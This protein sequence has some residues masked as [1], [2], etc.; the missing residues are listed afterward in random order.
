MSQ[1][2]LPINDQK[3]LDL[4]LTHRSYLN[5]HKNR[6]A[7]NERLEFLGDAVL[8]LATSEFIYRQFPQ[9]PEG[10]LTAL[11][12]SLVRTST[13]AEVATNLQLGDKLQLSKGEA[14]SGGRTNKALLANTFEAVVG[15][16][17]LDSGFQTVVSFLEANLFPKLDS[18]IKNKL[19]KDFKST[20]QET[21]QAQGKPTPEYKL[22]SQ[23]GP[24][25]EKHFTVAV[26]VGPTQLATGQGKSKQTAQQQAAKHALE[27]IAAD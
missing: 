27:K 14:Q 5:E 16:I 3:L 1:S 11:R 25:H 7:H 23:A 26:I 2:F 21:V 22:V 18:I 6:T 12:S 15:A 17:Y 13:L 4:A 10:D 20:L 9:K 8:E 24:D 19:Y